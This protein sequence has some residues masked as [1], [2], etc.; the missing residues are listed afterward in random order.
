MNYIVGRGN[1]KAEM[2]RERDRMV[3]ELSDLLLYALYHM[4]YDKLVK[5]YN[6]TFDQLGAKLDQ[7]VLYGMKGED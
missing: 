2:Q 6:Q 7:D 5:T 1:G 4:P 3:K